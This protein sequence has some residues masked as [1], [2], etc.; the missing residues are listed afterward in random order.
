MA[1][2]VIRAARERNV[3]C[4]VAPYEADAQLAFLAMTGVA[5]F[6]VTEDSDLTLFGCEKI[7][8]K[9]TD[10]GDCVLYEREHLSKVFGLQ[11]DHFN[12][13]KFRY[14]CIT[15]GCDYLARLPGIGLGKAKNFWQKVSNTDLTTVLRKIPAYLKMPQITVTQEY[16]DR[17]IK[18]N[19]TF[20]Y[21]V[22]FDPVTRKER[23]LTPYPDTMISEVAT[24]TYCG[25]YS[26]PNL[27]LQMALGNVNIFT[28]KQVD[29][30][31]PDIGVDITNVKPRYGNRATHRSVWNREFTTKGPAT[32]ITE[33]S[34][35][36]SFAFEMTGT[37]TTD[38]KKPLMSQSTSAPVAKSK[39]VEKRK[40]DISED[41]VE[42]L[43]MSEEDSNEPPPN[44][45]SKTN[46][47]SKLKKLAGLDNQEVKRNT[48]IISRYFK[49]PN[50]NQAADDSIR[51][52]R[53]STGESGKW[54]HD[55]EK[56]TSAAG[57][58]IYKPESSPVKT[59]GVLKEISNS[60]PAYNVDDEE[61]RQR[62]NPFAKNLKS[63]TESVRLELSQNDES[64]D[65]SA[66]SIPSSQI[67]LFSIDGESLT[68]SS[69]DTESISVDNQ[70]DSLKTT[71]L[72]SLSQTS[73]TS[74]MS[75]PV[76]SESQS[77]SQAPLSPPSRAP[78]VGL[79]KFANVSKNKSTLTTS[80]NNS[81]STFG[82]ARVSG[83][84]KPAS[85][86]KTG[87]GDGLKQT[88]L[89]QLFGRKQ[90]TANIGNQN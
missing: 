35:K 88:S 26:P 61:R 56:P 47:M 73:S 29:N 1:L 41:Q 81:K 86:N 40:L 42:K 50:E 71:E 37:R 17:F 78:R 48:K 82:P 23:P 72:V 39:G 63:S 54:F 83:L 87:A 27:A 66:T 6:V 19:N 13:D 28:K 25:S 30:Y 38:V 68:F 2:D 52:R 70:T 16:I 34:I 55:L 11:A 31:D 15:S 69:Q 60:P 8:F 14:M 90:V 10:A 89:M 77:S 5:D 76:L 65:N 45:R 9:L 74:P 49:K 12:F 36:D 75:S 18:A 53:L 44:K 22:V 67:S 80:R 51:G 3:D 33:M 4:I 32:K 43:L 7:L 84:S 24:L 59:D 79:S 20:L 57:K 58:F 64:A 46:D 85:A 62:R 21:Q